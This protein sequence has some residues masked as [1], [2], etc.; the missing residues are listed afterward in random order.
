MGSRI[1]RHVAP[2]SSR[3]EQHG[4]FRQVSEKIC[5]RFAGRNRFCRVRSRVCHAGLNQC[6]NSPRTDLPAIDRTA[7]TTH[8]SRRRFSMAI[9]EIEAPTLK[10][11]LSDGGEIALLDVREAGQFGE[12]HPFFA[13]PL[14][15]SRFE[16]GLPDLAPNPNVRL[17]L[18]DGGDGTAA[19]AAK[20]AEELGYQNLH[21]LE[22]GADAWTRAGYTLYA[23]VNVPSKTFGELIEHRRQTP[24]LTAA[25][26]QA[27][28]EAG[29]NMVIVDGRPFAEYHKM[30]IPGGI[31]CPNGELV[32][33]IGDIAPDA[34]TK[35]V[36]NCAGRTRSIIGAQTLIDFGVPN[37]VVAL[38]NGTQGWTLAGLTLEHG[39][40]RRHGD[41]IGG[42]VAAL[43]E[44]ARALGESHG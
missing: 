21:V 25:E 9:K 30:N 17:V 6:A 27:M 11:W 23:G 4:H 24:R 39:A 31:C 44:R 29:D 32:L 5:Q 13:V 42:N 10:A 26:L 8:Q 20:R 15:Y 34:N 36:V 41:S 22:G 18:T 40:S 14:P 2:S 19:R 1:G 43:A 38:Q 35:I 33:R 7:R 37:P 28:R 16:L 12:A 3:T